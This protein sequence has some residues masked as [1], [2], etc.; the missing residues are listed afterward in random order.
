MQS[1]TKSRRRWWVAPILLAAV[2]ALS[3]CGVRMPWDRPDIPDGL[4]PGVGTQQPYIDI[5]S[6]GRTAEKMRDW[7][8]PISEA[9]AIPLTALEAYGNA[10]EI[11]R[12][13]HPECGIG[14]TTLAGIAAV[15]TKHGRHGGASVAPN[16][17]VRPKIRGPEL[18]GTNGNRVIRDT[19]KGKLD[20]D[21]EYDRAMG[22]FQFIP[23]TWMR[24][25]V[26]AN[27]D[28]V[29]D[30]DN[31]DDA[32]LSAARYLCVY[33]GGDMTTPEGWE[34]AVHAYNNHDEYVLKVRNYAN[35]YSVNIR[36]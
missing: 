11:Q 36:Y 23:E 4:P 26:D 8:T 31:I 33:S 12:Q 3:S 21:T 35:A 7:A 16:G 32:A 29:A 13:Q 15:E 25:G 6:P 10:A 17:D 5:N 20:G 28:G 30:P 18:D 24:Y 27:G 1:A 14:W 34:K 2:L 19:D 22:P 9:T